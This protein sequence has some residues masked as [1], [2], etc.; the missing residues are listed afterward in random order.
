MHTTR[1][2]SKDPTESNQTFSPPLRIALVY[3]V[4][5]TLWIL[6]S[7]NV[8]L[9]FFAEDMYNLSFIQTIKG[10]FYVLATAAV[11][12]ILIQRDIDKLKQSKRKLESSYQATLEGWVQ[13][14]QLR[15]E[16][17]QTH[18]QRVIERT[19]LLAQEMGLN[20]NCLTHIRRGALLHDIGKL[21][22][23]DS[24][25]LKPGKLSEDERGVIEKHPIYAREFLS[26]IE[27]LKPA[28]P[29]PYYH[30]ER[31]D[32]KGYPIGL[33]REEIPLEARIFAVIDVWDALTSDRPYRKAWS[34]E[35]ATQYIL[36]HAG[37][38]FDPHVVDMW[39]KV[40]DIPDIKG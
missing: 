16:E 39:S 40:F 37:T 15:D 2:K 24:I 3:L 19:V 11:L 23:S 12:Y 35:K 9:L 26:G 13:A 7:D 36:D 34:E 18:T 20:G 1:H 33:K 4:L 21:G 17:T 22:I 6:F 32:G 25:L 30:H 29:I 31:W 10:G 14:L 27:F 28:L 38:H 5:G 8:A